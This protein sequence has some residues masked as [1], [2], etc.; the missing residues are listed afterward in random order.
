MAFKVGPTHRTSPHLLADLMELVLLTKFN[1]TDYWAKASLADAISREEIHPEEQDQIRKESSVDEQEAE[2]MAAIN[3]K[4]SV[5][6][7]DV[8]KQLEYRKATFGDSYPFE[9]DGNTIELSEHFAPPA[10]IY[11]LLVACSRLRSFEGS[12]R[13]EWAKYFATVCADALRALVRDEMEVRIFDANS[14]DRHG[15]YGTDLREALIKLGLDLHPHKVDEDECRRQSSSGDF[16]IDLVAHYPIRDNAAGTMVI[17]GQCGAQETEWPSKKLEGHPV[18]LTTIYSLVAQ[19]MHS[20]FIPLCF[21]DSTGRWGNNSKVA[22]CL[23]FDRSRILQLLIKANKVD[24]ILAAPWF[25]K[26]EA[27]FS[28][29][30]VEDVTA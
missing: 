12:I 20:L 30:A 16:G 27:D 4:Q 7:E 6:V 26:F 19:P 1:Q 15:Y 11:S 2:G 21:R 23:L 14:I 24:G 3:D 28:V 25:E 29:S 8:W 22:G 9:I 13:V 5:W 17:L 18:T 10:R